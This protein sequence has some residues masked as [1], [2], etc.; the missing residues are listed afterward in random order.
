[1]GRCVSASI[2]GGI[3][4]NMGGQEPAE[5]HQGRKECQSYENAQSACRLE[6]QIAHREYKAE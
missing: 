1:M 6:G 4:E 5:R 2:D 3:L